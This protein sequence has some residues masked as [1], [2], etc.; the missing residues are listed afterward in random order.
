M[1]MD[2][3]WSPFLISS[4]TII[5]GRSLSCGG[6]GE[7]C[8]VCLPQGIGLIAVSLWWRAHRGNVTQTDGIAANGAFRECVSVAVNSPNWHWWMPNCT[9]FNKNDCSISEAV[10]FADKLSDLS[11]ATSHPVWQFATLNANQLVFVASFSKRARMIPMAVEW[12][13]F[14]GQIADASLATNWP[15]CAQVWQT[16]NCLCCRDYSK[17]PFCRFTNTNY[18]PT[19]SY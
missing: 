13:V 16:H 8:W 9:L 17:Y 5:T 3:I 18:Y 2:P 19:F 7:I 1:E 6:E 4:L 15:L 11:P 12:R 14:M 10:I